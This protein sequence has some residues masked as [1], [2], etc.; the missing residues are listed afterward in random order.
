MKYIVGMDV[1]TLMDMEADG[2]S[3]YDGGQKGE[4]LSIL[5]ANGVNSV[6]VRLWLDP[7][8]ANGE[9]YGA[10]T[11]DLS[12]VIGI[13]KRAKALGMSFLLDFHYSDFWTDPEKQ[14]LPKAWR[15]LSFEELQ[16]A[17][18]D[19]SEKTLAELARAGCLPDMIQVGNEITHGMLWP[20][21]KLVRDGKGGYEGYDRLC[22]LLESAISGIKRIT[23]CPLMIH[24]ERSYD[25]A[26]YR[27]FFDEL[28][29]RNVRFDAIGF[30]YYPYWHHGFAEL[31][32]NMNDMAV[33]YGK[34]LYIAE[35]AY[36]FTTEHFPGGGK[37]LVIDGNFRPEAGQSLPFPLTPEGQRDYC[38]TLLELLVGVRNFKGIYYWEPAWIPSK[39]GT[40]ASAGAREYIG[41][42]NAEGGNEWANQ[43]LFDYDGNSL[44]ALKEFE[45][46][47]DKYNR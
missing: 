12:R 11:C 5:K 1:S 8:D 33:R 35:T 18:R 44:P 39:N 13:A 21:G 6:R 34:D 4:L 41:A 16:S 24:L 2:V 31:A 27:N 22:A 40:W 26:H 36:A 15:D 23:D 25:N 17:V 7:Y 29:A 3:Y 45:K 43:C 46:F 37:S 10:G 20:H 32:A 19:Y 47:S 9:T 14:F 28:T 30:S 42:R 38:R